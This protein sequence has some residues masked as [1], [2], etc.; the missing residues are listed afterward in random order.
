MIMIIDAIKSL[1][2]NAE[3]II[4][5]NSFDDI[6]FLNGTPTISIAKITAKIAELELAEPMRV[7]RQQ[8][9]NLLSATDWQ[10]TSDRTMSNDQ[11][12]YRQQLRDL[13]ENSTPALDEDGNLTGVTWPTVPE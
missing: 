5:N 9:N 2:A 7:L 1:N 12:I 3:V 11:Q 10:A 4:G 13:P 8:R 6:R